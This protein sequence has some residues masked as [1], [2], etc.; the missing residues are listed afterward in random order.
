MVAYFCL[1]VTAPAWAA[2]LLSNG[3]SIPLELTQ[4][5]SSEDNTV[6]QPVQFRVV[7]DIVVGNYLLIKA[8]SLATGEI[9]SIT[10]RGAIGKNGN[11]TIQAKNVYGVDGTL[12]NISAMKNAAGEE[13]Q[14]TSIVL[15][16][17]CC[18]LFLIMRG[19]KGI[20]SVG[21]P[22]EAMVLG[23]QYIKGTPVSSGYIPT[24]LPPTPR[25]EKKDKKS[26]NDSKYE[27]DNQKAGETSTE[28]TTTTTPT[29]SGTSK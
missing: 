15:T 20:L 5:V 24:V 26:K 25:P 4:Q 22:L 1:F 19:E 17:L 2:V 11:V 8:G 14:T 9:I 6:G 13:K 23:N 27:K 21:T 3:T 7:K 10:K 12:I 29:S 16:V 28:T 18:I